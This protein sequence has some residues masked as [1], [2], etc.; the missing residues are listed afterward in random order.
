MGHPSDQYEGISSLFLQAE[1]Q[2][3]RLGAERPTVLAEIGDP[4][5]ADVLDLACGAGAYTRLLAQHG[6]D[7]VVGVDAS[8]DM[9]AAAERIEHPDSARISYLVHDVQTMPVLGAFD[10]ATA[11][12]LLNYA[13]SADEL[14]AMCLSVHANLRPGGRFV[15]C[16]PNPEFDRG[17]PL[18]P[19][20]PVTP[21]F[22]RAVEDGQELTL[23]LIFTE[24]LT[25]RF[26]YW[27][28]AT[29]R[30]ALSAAGFTDVRFRPQVPSEQALAEYGPEFWASWLANPLN[31]VFSATRP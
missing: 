6:A 25:I 23:T 19:A 13:R 5:G 4:S 27:S 20:Y 14:T 1:Q 31:I 11:V 28:S 30:T 26:R 8:A 3:L 17:R 22:P 10:L 18:N 2:V 29:Y 21:D 7:R 24:P 15:G 16:V 9:V 12:Y